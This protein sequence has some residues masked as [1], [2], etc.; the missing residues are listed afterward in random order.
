[1]SNFTL[2]IGN[3]NY[4]S[5]SLRAW[6]WIRHIGLDFDEV[7]VSLHNESLSDQLDPYF[8]DTKVPVLLHDG[9]EVWDSLA[10]LEYLVSLYPEQGL[11][12][13]LKARAVARSLCAEMHSSFIALRN[14]LPMNC[15]REP[16]PLLLSD[17]C[18]ADIDRIQ[19]LWQYAGNYSEG[20]GNWLFGNFGIADAMFAP[21]VLR[22]NRYQVALS[23]P[24][25]DYVD[26]FL[27]HPAM[28]EWVAAGR[29]ETDIIAQEER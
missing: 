28:I 13:G 22:F 19:S 11:P 2:V 6:L 12:E 10:I 9:L 14:E 16:S 25:S 26:R 20:D 23:K 24:A 17:T 21:V 15:R 27:D 1:M 3:K 18:I 8:S 4:S 29:A 7:P 5:W